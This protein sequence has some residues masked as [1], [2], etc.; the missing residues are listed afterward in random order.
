MLFIIFKAWYLLKNNE[1]LISVVT[2]C[3]YQLV[4]HLQIDNGHQ[5]LVGVYQQ[6]LRHLVGGSRQ[7]WSPWPPEGD[8]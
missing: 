6:M 7:L 1:F 8:Q 5:K 3:S 4:S 2:L